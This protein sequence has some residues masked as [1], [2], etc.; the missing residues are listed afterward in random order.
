[1]ADESEKTAGGI[2]GRVLKIVGILAGGW[3]LKNIDGIIKTVQK[4]VKVI[5]GCL[6]WN[7]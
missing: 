4:A 3:L 6:E 1:M 2:L 7:R 5:T